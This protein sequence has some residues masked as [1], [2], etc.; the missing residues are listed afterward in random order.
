MK[1]LGIHVNIDTEFFLSGL[2]VPDRFL[3]A[4]FKSLNA[5]IL[6]S[7]PLLEDAV[8]FPEQAVG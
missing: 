6:V 2:Q 4:I 7:Y 3:N 5:C 1:A 8:A